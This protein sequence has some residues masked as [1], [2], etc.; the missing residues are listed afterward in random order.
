M[1]CTRREFV[2]GLT[3]AGTE[4][5]FGVWPQAVDAEPPPETTRLR[6]GDN[7][8]NTRRGIV[9]SH[10]PA[11]RRCSVCCEASE[12]FSITCISIS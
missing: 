2:S 1:N 6:I 8:F 12:R 4:G 10:S 9:K 5:L 7:V 11:E 3:L